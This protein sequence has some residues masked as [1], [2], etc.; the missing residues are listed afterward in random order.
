MVMSSSVMAGIAMR[1]TV[2]AKAKHRAG[3]RRYEWHGESQVKLG[4][5]MR[6]PVKV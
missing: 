2:F 6:R 3:W 4:I 1:C 5:T